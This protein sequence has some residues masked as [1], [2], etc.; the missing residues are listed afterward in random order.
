MSVGFSSFPLNVSLSPVKV[1]S[2]PAEN[3]VG[4]ALVYVNI[5]TEPDLMYKLVD[6]DHN[7]SFTNLF[8]NQII[9]V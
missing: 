7:K 3:S 5:F 1:S 4:K 8:M 9:F 6:S 2:S